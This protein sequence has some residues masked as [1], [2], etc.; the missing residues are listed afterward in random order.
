M[1]NSVLVIEPYQFEGI[2]VF[3]DPAV[4]LKQEPFVAGITEMIDRLTINIPN[5]DKGFRLLFSVRPFEG[6]QTVLSWLRADAIE[7]N[8]YRAEDQ[9]D[10]GWLCPALFHYFPEPPK[11]IFIKAE[12]KKKNRSPGSSITLSGDVGQCGALR[13]AGTL[14]TSGWCGTLI[15][16]MPSVVPSSRSSGFLIDRYGKK[17]A[18][19]FETILIPAWP[20]KKKSK[21]RYNPCRPWR[22][23]YA[24]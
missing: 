9:G 7:G 1:P 13:G 8:W 2:W 24:Y 10:E 23:A 3:D 22:A 18:Y 19:R 4:G 14:S 21:H 20:Q 11:N 16:E 12:P 5:A 6:H 15:F 17:C